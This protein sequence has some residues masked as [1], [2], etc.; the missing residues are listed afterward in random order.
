METAISG[1]GSV[2]AGWGVCEALWEPS[3]RGQVIYC[4]LSGTSLAGKAEGF[5]WISGLAMWPYVQHSRMPVPG[6]RKKTS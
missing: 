6:A 1:P 2:P 5:A 4:S 3:S